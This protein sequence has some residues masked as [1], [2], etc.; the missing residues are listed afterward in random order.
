[1]VN[2]VI[3]ARVVYLW[4]VVGSESERQAALL[5]ARRTPGVAGVEDHLGILP[6]AGMWGI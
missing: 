6:A 1:M 2:V 5:A 3:A 4:G